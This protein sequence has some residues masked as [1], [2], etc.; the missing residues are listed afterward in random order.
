MVDLISRPVSGNTVLLFG[1]QALSFGEDS[2]LQIRSSILES[3]DFGWILDSIHDLPKWLKIFSKEHSKIQTEPGLRLLEDL[4]VWLKDGGLPHRLSRLP[5]ILLN[6]L[7]IILQLTQ[8]FKYIQLA[9]DRPETDG[10]HVSGRDRQETVGFCTGFLSALAVSS[11]ATKG[12]F[13][14]FGAVA[15]RIGMLIGMVVDAQDAQ[16]DAGESV[17]LATVW[18]SVESKK[19]MGRIMENFPEVNMFMKMFV[20]VYGANS[21]YR[22]MSLS[23]MMKI[24]PR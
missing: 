21:V 24:E 23:I 17:S 20:S 11:S 14:R 6:P 4:S 22:L 15:L 8:Y 16:T 12:D 13:Q 19:E 7:V 2:F 5:N 1:P 10:L 3:D 18:N 9:H